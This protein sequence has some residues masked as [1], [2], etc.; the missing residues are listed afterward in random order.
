[1][2]QWEL[3]FAQKVPKA[4]LFLLQNP[5]VATARAHNLRVTSS[6]QNQTLNG[7]HSSQFQK[8]PLGSGSIKALNH[9]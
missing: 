3:T 5:E 8:V 9:V 2:K 1:M 4:N 7:M 6:R